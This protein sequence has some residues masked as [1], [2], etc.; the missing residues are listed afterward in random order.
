MIVFIKLRK[1][2]NTLRES[3]RSERELSSYNTGSI[4]LTDTLIKKSNIRQGPLAQSRP[5]VVPQ[6]TPLS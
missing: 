6:V 3:E 1:Y 5:G 4:L 2:I